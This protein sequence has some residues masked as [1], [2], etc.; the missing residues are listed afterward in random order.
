MADTNPASFE[1]ISATLTSYDEQTVKDISSN[2]I[3]GFELNQSMDMT[4]YNG[5]LTIL[6]TVGLLESMPIRGEE[7]LDLVI[8]S[9]DLNTEVKIKGFIHKVSDIVPTQ[10]SN[11]VMYKLHFVSYETFK[12]TTRRVIQAYTDS[13]ENMVK[14]L[15]ENN[16]SRLDNEITVDPKN[17]TRVLPYNTK[18]YSLIDNPD[19][20][21]FIQRTNGTSNLVIPRLIPP[22]AMY[23]VASRGYNPD[24]PSQTFRF[25]ETVDSYYF[26]T[27]EFFIKGVSDKDLINLFYAPVID[28]TPESMMSQI[29]RIESL[30]IMSKGI[31][32]STDLFSGSYRNEVVEIDLIRK[33]FEHKKFNF[34]NAKYIDMTGD[35]RNL[36][37]NPHTKQFRNDY[38][39]E[40]NAKRFMI[41]KNYQS[42]GDN[43]STLNND[44][45]F[46]D[47]VQ[48]RVS[49]YHHLNG[50]SLI[51]TLKGRLDIKPGMIANLDIKKLEGVSNSVV[52]NDTLSGRYLIQSISHVLS[53]DGSLLASLKMAK[54]D[55]SAPANQTQPD[56]SASAGDN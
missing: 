32:T 39:R 31:D 11:G 54:F 48:N 20:G 16:Y 49:Y 26:C 30:Q 2:F 19:R 56:T 29:N 50:T 44:M 28:Y 25:F 45:H 51:A 38:F 52:D 27:D 18:H 9:F 46:T 8:K 53:E 13:V 4:S 33:K 24:T 5:A 3:G 34:D 43:P 6:D 15:F 37:T 42:T 41:F 55:W 36:E 7:I 1:F 40:D 14:D 22:E 23:F 21:L 17:D 12:A 47:I 10:S 35:V